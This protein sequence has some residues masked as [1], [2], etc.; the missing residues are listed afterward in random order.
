M[1]ILSCIF[2]IFYIVQ[3]TVVVLKPPLL[4]CYFIRHISYVFLIYHNSVLDTA[5][6]C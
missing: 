3:D 4:C 2:D 1:H 5:L 6:F